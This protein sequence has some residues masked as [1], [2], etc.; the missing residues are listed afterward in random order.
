MWALSPLTRWAYVC[1]MC[2]HLSGEIT[3][4]QWGSWV[5]WITRKSSKHFLSPSFSFSFYIFLSFFLMEISNVA[6]CDPET[7]SW[8]I[9]P[10]SF[11][12]Q[13]LHRIRL[14]SKI[15]NNKTD[16]K[17]STTFLYLNITHAKKRLFNCSHSQEHQKQKQIKK[18]KFH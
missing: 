11:S 8:T 6:I 1:G 9:T 15:Q 12:R 18:Q 14:D 10:C 4:E 16:I 5:G 2:A 3:R 17:K 13:E 7:S